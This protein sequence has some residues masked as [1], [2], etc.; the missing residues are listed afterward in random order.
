MT[1]E[2]LS[3]A[4]LRHYLDRSGPAARRDS[5][6]HHLDRC[7]ACW[8]RWNEHR[9]NAARTHPLYDELARHLGPAFEPGRDSS[10]DL[11]TEWDHADPSAP[12]EVAEFFRTSTSYL[13]NLATW[14]ASGNRPDYLTAALPHLIAHDIRTVLDIGSGIGSDALALQRHGF[15]VT[16]CDYDSPSTRFARWRSH[17]TLTVI[18]PDQLRPEH[19]GEALWITDTLDHLSDIEIA[20]GHVLPHTRLVIT[21]DLHDNRAH[22]RQRFHHRRTLQEIAA[23]FAHD[24]LRP[25]SAAGP[26]M[27]WTRKASGRTWRPSHP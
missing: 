8:A 23:V 25:E 10:R 16:G 18:K 7:E 5:L 1:S 9:W 26:V 27:A 22:G 2:H 12:D 14:E 4:D 6:R 20:I 13:Y 21:E 3:A 24:G 19:A 15:Q 11:A 17:G